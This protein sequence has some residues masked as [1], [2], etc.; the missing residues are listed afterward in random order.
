MAKNNQVNEE[1]N[2]SS[3]ALKKR[4]HS[5][6]ISPEQQARRAAYNARDY[7]KQIKDNYYRQNKEALYARKKHKRAVIKLVKQLDS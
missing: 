7:V 1:N 2:T 6:V 5:I 4:N 3:P